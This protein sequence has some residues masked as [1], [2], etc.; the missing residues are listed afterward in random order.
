MPKQ[1]RSETAV[2]LGQNPLLLCSRGLIACRHPPL[3]SSYLLR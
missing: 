1:L 2:T 3:S